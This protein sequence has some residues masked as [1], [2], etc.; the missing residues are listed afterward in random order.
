MAE[1]DWS[2]I[3]NKDLEI[4]ANTGSFEGVSNETLQYIAGESGSAWDAFTGNAQRGLTS[5]LRGLGIMQPDPEADLEAEQKSRMALETNPVAGWSGLIIGSILDP[6]TLPA[7][8][9]KPLAIGGKVATAALRGS[10]VGAFG[11]AIE[12]TYETM[13]DSRAMNI[14]GGVVLGGALGAGAAVL[15]RKFGIDVDPAKVTDENK[16]EVEAKVQAQVDALPE[17]QKQQLLLEW[18]GQFT[19][20]EPAFTMPT[21]PVEWNNELKSLETVETVPSTVDL[22][23]PA[24]VKKQ[25]QINKINTEFADDLD[26]ALWQV[27][28]SKGVPKQTATTWL[29]E[30]TGMN[31]RQVEVLAEQAKRELARK[32]AGLKPDGGKLKFTSPSMTSSVIKSRIAPDRI[33]REPYQPKRID[34]KDGLDPEDIE[35]LRLTGVIVT[36]LPNGSIQFRD[37][38]NSAHFLT[39][40]ELKHRM[41]AVG[42]DL[43]VPGYRQKIK[44]AQ[45]VPKEEL[46]KILKEAPTEQ[47][48]NFFREASDVGKADIPLPPEVRAADELLSAIDAGGIPL[49]P[50]KLN[51]IARDLGLD[52]SAKAKPEETIS[53]I[54]GA[55]ERAKSS[56][57]AEPADIGTPK[58]YGSVGSA[59]VDPKT[60]LTEDLMPK[61]YNDIIKGGEARDRVL[62]RMLENDDPRLAIPK[63]IDPRVMGKGTLLATKQKARAT[64]QKILDDY[65]NFPAFMI[66]RKGEARGMSDD[67]TAAFR[68][69]YADAMANRARIFDD[70][71][72]MRNRGDS[73]DSPRGAELARDL[74]YY[75]GVDMFWKN[76]GTKISRALNAR[77][78]IYQYGSKLKTIFPGTNCL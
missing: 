30:K 67:E 20:R 9:L 15:L 69:F 43:D 12:P 25:I 36:R 66:A 54:R 4:I 76:E 65:G 42:I 52:V 47:E 10:A 75:E 33:V 63:D 1:I 60:Y 41:N 37:A 49:N 70:L 24:Q 23:M 6:V 34:I 38:F 44:A 28:T 5:S 77:K 13:G 3:P 32:V 61:T 59:G 31:Q 62:L 58:A 53:R 16:A 55:V 2:L 51:N 14:A 74:T 72:E 19:P 29:M 7:T 35:K 48:A 40:A 18:N 46:N 68:W 39:S 26:H 57:R 8:V 56:S 73:F 22:N 78:I 17:E 64:L 71:V 27:S 11:G 45:A 50:K 21:K